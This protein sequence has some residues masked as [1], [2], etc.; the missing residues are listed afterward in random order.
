MGRSITSTTARRYGRTLGSI[1]DE[2]R[3]EEQAPIAIH[4]ETTSLAR[5]AAATIDARKG[6]DIALLDMS[7][8]LVITDIFVLA[9]GTSR[10]HV[11]TLAEEVVR[12]LRGTGR[13]PL[14]KEGADDGQ[15]VLLDYGDVV[16]HVFD[17]DT[18][19]HYDLERLWGSADRLEYER[20]AP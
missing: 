2:T 8:L 7:E 11:R 20:V 5:A 6:I 18:R 1:E 16:V 17:P 4:P 3:A 10:R 13:S 19:S 14:R 12:A 15:W 9:T